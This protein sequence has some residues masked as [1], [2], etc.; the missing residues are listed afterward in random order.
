MGP[1]GTERLG[2][3]NPGRPASGHPSI[4]LPF[5]CLNISVL[6]APGSSPSKPVISVGIALLQV[7]GKSKIGNPGCS[8]ASCGRV[9]EDAHG[10]L[11]HATPRDTPT[12]HTRFFPCCSIRFFISWDSSSLYCGHCLILPDTLSIDNDLPAGP[13]VSLPCVCTREIEI[14]PPGSHIVCW[15][16]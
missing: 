16:L 8:F 15:H 4:C 2:L 12:F 7:C 3:D 5:P 1:V 6:P 9:R 13:L 14:V 10:M 11:K